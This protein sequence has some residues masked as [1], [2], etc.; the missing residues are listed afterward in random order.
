MKLDPE[1]S[2]EQPEAAEQK[3]F[4]VEDTVAARVDYIDGKKVGDE[5]KGFSL[6]K[7]RVFAPVGIEGFRTAGPAHDAGVMDW[8]RLDLSQTVFGP[9][10][11][12]LTA[13]ESEGLGPM[14]STEEEL[15]ANLEGVVLRLNKLLEA[16]EAEQH[17][18][19]FFNGLSHRLVPEAHVTY[20]GTKVGDEMKAFTPQDSGA[21][22]VSG[23]VQPGPAH[24]A[25]VRD[26][27][28]LSLSKTLGECN[29]GSKPDLTEEL[30]M[31]EPEKLL[32]L[33]DITLVFT[34]ASPDPIQ[35]C[36]HS[37]GDGFSS[38]EIAE[39]SATAYFETDGDGSS[40]PDRR[41]GVTCLVLPKDVTPLQ[42]SEQDSSN[43]WEFT[44]TDGLAI[45][46][47]TEPAMDAEKT[48]D[49]I[50]SGEIMSIS[51]E[52]V[53]D[54]GVTYLKLADGRGWI[55]NQLQDGTVLCCK[56]DGH[57]WNTI[58]ENAS[59]LKSRVQGS[60]SAP[61][62]SREDWDDARLRALCAKHGWEFDWM[63]EDGERRRRGAERQALVTMPAHLSIKADSACPDGFQRETPHGSPLPLSP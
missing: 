3:C 29:T 25:G 6:D 38:F 27:W 12:A 30:L 8:W 14:P 48:G 24:L 61:M 2:Q 31:T 40:Y 53:G 13:L 46:I 1:E 5:I 50:S 17:T 28:E 54:D 9:S 42:D 19:F 63:T 15:L 62:L 55:F 44:K 16:S 32:E 56:S 35:R 52:V 20:K 58:M 47:R 4:V 41:W 60:Q 23:F 45:G 49:S 37:G 21:M 18:L 51:E 39:N 43:C 36:C 22:M 26:G 34:C 33:Q 10:N 11:T 59:K 57:V 7:S